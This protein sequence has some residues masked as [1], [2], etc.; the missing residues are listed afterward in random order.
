[1]AVTIDN[2]DSLNIHPRN[3]KLVGERL[4]RWALY[5]DYDRKNIVYSGPLYKSYKISGNKITIS[6]DDTDGGLVAKDGPLKEFTIAGSDSAFI[7]AQA[8]IKGKTVVVWSDAIKKP[9]AVR[10]AWKNVPYPNLYNKADLPASPFRTDRFKLLTEGKKLI[11]MHK[12]RSYHVWLRSC[13][14][15]P[16]GHAHSR[17]PIG[18][19][20]SAPGKHPLQKQSLM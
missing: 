14:L 5:N 19:P 3:K 18:R 1:M 15:P 7:P 8:I 17:I 11:T 12:K 16:W 2:G 6:F 20:K 10:F 13:Y 9:V 4:A